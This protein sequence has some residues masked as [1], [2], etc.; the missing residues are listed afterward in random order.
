[1]SRYAPIGEYPRLTF[2]YLRSVG[3]DPTKV[4]KPAL[5]IFG[6]ISVHVFLS[7]Q[8]EQPVIE[9]VRRHGSRHYRQFVK[10]SVAFLK[11]G[12]RWYFVCPVTGRR[13]LF[14]YYVCGQFISRDAFYQLARRSP[15]SPQAAARSRVDWLMGRLNG[16]DGRGPARGNRRQDHLRELRQYDPVTL[17]HPTV[18]ALLAGEHRKAERRVRRN[19]G[20]L[21]RKAELAFD[22]AWM[23]GHEMRSGHPLTDYLAVAPE[24]LRTL[25]STVPLGHIDATTV[26]LET[27]PSLDIASILS[28]H[29]SR[30]ASF[31]GVHLAWPLSATGG[32]AI[33][34]CVDRR[35]GEAPLLLIDF[36]PADRRPASRQIVALA[37]GGR[38]QRWFM[39][40][41]VTGTLANQLYLRHGRFASRAAQRL[42]YPS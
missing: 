14:L 36:V 25:P 1:M 29:A 9:V 30:T 37:T 34:L 22:D 39:Q 2:S 35:D 15:Y 4:G 13:V 42:T 10:L 16:T 3:I 17:L 31:W 12:C 33:S 38:G 28:V 6:A 41:P 11:F 5:L 32:A 8:N 27:R 21:H 40:C 19:L 7:F 18:A 24:D 20:V 26:S 23:H